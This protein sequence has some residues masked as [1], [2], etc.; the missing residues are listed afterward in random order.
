MITT[1]PLFSP[2]QGGNMK[3]QKLNGSARKWIGISI[4]F[5]FMTAFFITPHGAQAQSDPNIKKLMRLV[6]RGD[7]ARL[8]NLLENGANPNA[9]DKRGRTPLI[10]AALRGRL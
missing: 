2:K 4:A 1:R 6:G 9:V 10:H 7:F 3:V 8:K 5:I